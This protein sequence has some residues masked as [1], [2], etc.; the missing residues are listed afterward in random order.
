M[1]ITTTNQ[2]AN[3]ITGV[4]RS[5][6]QAFFATLIVALTPIIEALDIADEVT[7]TA[8]VLTSLVVAVV[9]GAY[10]WILTTLSHMP[11]VTG[12]PIL[13]AVVAALMGGKQSPVYGGSTANYTVVNPD[14]TET[15]LT[16]YID[17]KFDEK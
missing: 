17:T 8:A 9:L 6:V 7:A 5:A 1:Q 15:S 12:N 13:A 2:T 3:K 11:V 16:D 10:W 4:V 14:G